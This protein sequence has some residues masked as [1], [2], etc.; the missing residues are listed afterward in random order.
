MHKEEIEIALYRLDL[1]FLR[2]E[3]CECEHMI[4][5]H[6]NTIKGHNPFWHC[7]GWKCSCREYVPMTNLK[8]LALREKIN[9][10]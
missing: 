7:R 8:Y 2:G 1:R 6:T 10:S 9:E 3:L 4:Q 5:L